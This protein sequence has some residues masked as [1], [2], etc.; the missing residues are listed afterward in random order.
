MNPLEIVISPNAS[1]SRQAN[2]LLFLSLTIII[3]VVAAGFTLMGYWV[4]LPFAGLELAALA[5]ALVY[6]DYQNQYREVVHVND[7]TVKVESGYRKA[8]SA[9]EFKRGWTSVLLRD[10][11][12]HNRPS[13]LVLRSA[14]KQVEIGACLAS[15]DRKD[16]WRELKQI[17]E[18]PQQH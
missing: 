11:S 15:D 14:G 12:K 2:I 16:L 8:Q 4:I 9:C 13:K 7:H 17:I 1:L 3:L 5:T 10:E 18:Q 6:V